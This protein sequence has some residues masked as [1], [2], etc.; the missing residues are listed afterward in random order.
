MGIEYQILG[1]PGKDN[2][3]YVRLNSGSKMYRL[4][5][6]CGEKTLEDLKQH[7][8][9][10]INYIFFSHLHIDHI[11]GFDYF[12]SRNYDRNNRGRNNV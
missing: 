5:F 11:G 3:L 12:F 10:G 9:K 1:R 7:D 2:A 4:L 6:D 8:V